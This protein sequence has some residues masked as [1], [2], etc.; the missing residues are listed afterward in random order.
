MIL[1]GR[2]SKRECQIIVLVFQKKIYI[3]SLFPRGCH[4]FQQ[5]GMIC[6]YFIPMRRQHKQS[7]F[8]SFLQWRRLILISHTIIFQQVLFLVLDLLPEWIITSDLLKL[9]YVLAILFCTNPDID[10]VNL[11]R[12]F[13]QGR[14][15]RY[16]ERNGICLRQK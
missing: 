16:Y 5:Q 8:W 10:V 15:K 11:D 6:N 2:Y 1:F 3:Y 13:L 9:I 4:M 12:L 7:I 14:V